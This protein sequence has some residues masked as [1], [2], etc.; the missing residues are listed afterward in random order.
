MGRNRTMYEDKDYVMKQIESEI[1]TQLD[2]I[3]KK[4]NIEEKVLSNKVKK[5]Y[6]YNDINKWIKYG[7][8]NGLINKDDKKGVY[9][10]V[11]LLKDLNF[12]V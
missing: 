11:K 5:V 2:D 3:D 4:E 9:D 1:K 6:N 7:L 12:E 10:W 8:K